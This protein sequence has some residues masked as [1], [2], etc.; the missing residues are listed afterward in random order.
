MLLGKLRKVEVF[1]AARLLVPFLFEAVRMVERG[2][3][4]PEVT[5]VVLKGNF[6]PPP[7]KQFLVA[8]GKKHIFV[9]H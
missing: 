2:D 6:A 4:K 5:M 7:K 3:A 1:F 8:C 9:G